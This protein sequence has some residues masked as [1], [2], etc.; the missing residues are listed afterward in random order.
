MAELVVKIAE[1]NK[2]LMSK[3]SLKYL[4]D[5]CRGSLKFVIVQGLYIKT[6]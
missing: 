3:I 2:E 1:K 4:C 5:S 6:E